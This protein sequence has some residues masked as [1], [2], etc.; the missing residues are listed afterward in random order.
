MKQCPT[1][2]LQFSASD[3]PRLCNYLLTDLRQLNLSCSRFGQSED[4]FIWSVG[5]KRSVCQPLRTP[6]PS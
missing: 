6:H 4:V 5:P 1:L 3:G 2:S